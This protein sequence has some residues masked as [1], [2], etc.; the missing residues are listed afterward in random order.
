MATEPD[1]YWAKLLKSRYYP[2]CT[3]LGACKGSRASWAWSSILDGREIILKGARW[4]VLNGNRV[5]LRVDNWLRCSQDSILRP[6]SGHAV[7]L[8][9]PVST[10]INPISLDWNLDNIRHM[11]SEHD[12]RRILSLPLGDGNEGDR[13][14]WPHN[15]N[16]EYSVKS[17]YNLIKGSSF[18]QH[19]DRPSGS[20]SYLQD[21]WKVIWKSTLIPK[22][23]NFLRRMFRGCLPTKDALFRRHLGVTSFCPLFNNEPE[24]K[25]HMFLMC[26]WVQYVWFGGPLTIRV[27]HQGVTNM[28]E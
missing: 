8:H 17:G 20:R 21:L 27:D 16:G 23:K 2:H 19:C 24:T 14:I 15:K 3:I 5:K 10:I 1:S 6:T 26:G 28:E 12:V 9:A 18:I 13:L 4:Q 7:D 11:I 22:L 25:E